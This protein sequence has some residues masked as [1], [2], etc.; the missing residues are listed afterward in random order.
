MLLPQG[1]TVSELIHVITDLVIMQSSYLCL[2][3]MLSHTFALQNA[4]Q[5]LKKL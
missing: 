2:S 4:V 3:L 1:L 5:L